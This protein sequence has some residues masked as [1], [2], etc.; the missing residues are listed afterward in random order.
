MGKYL[1]RRIL[2]GIISI[3]AVVAIVM[4]M[5]YSLTDREKIFASDAIFSKKS[6]NQRVT[7]KYEQW[8]KYGY[9]DYVTYNEFLINKVNSGEMT[10]EDRKAAVEI[11]EVSES[12][13]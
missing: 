4:I 1:L 3:F 5:L 13:E 9:M 8:E 7:Y 6:S 10:E 11:A 2:H 12:T